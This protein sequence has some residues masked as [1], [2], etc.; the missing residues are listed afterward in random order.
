MVY[1]GVGWCQRLKMFK[2]I[3]QKGQGI[4]EES[5]RWSVS[6]RGSTVSWSAGVQNGF[7]DGGGAFDT[8]R[9]GRNPPESSG[10]FE[11][12]WT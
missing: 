9:W 1:G 8:V 7:L 2:A 4:V 12:L 5:R 10:K 6:I 11:P 3:V